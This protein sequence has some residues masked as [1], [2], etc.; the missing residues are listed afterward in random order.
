MLKIIQSNKTEVLFDHLL[1]EYRKPTDARSVFEP[2][3]VIVP[4]KVL[5]EWLKT[6]VADQTGISTLVTTE[7]WGRYFLGLMQRVLRTYERLASEKDVPRVPDVPMLSKNVM[8]WQIF[9]YLLQHA[10]QILRDDK[11]PLY[12]FIQP[13]LADKQAHQTVSQPANAS[14]TAQQNSTTDWANNQSL[15]GDTR[16]SDA[17][18]NRSHDQRLWQFAGDMAA[19]LSRYLTY[20]TDWLTQWNREQALPIAQMIAERDDFF[21]RLNGRSTTAAD[22]TPD[23]LVEHYKTLEAAQRFLWQTLFV[24]DFA[25]RQA[26]HANF[27]QALHERRDWI[28]RACRAQLPAS[29]L[30]FTVQQLPPSEL[31]EIERLAELT[32]ITLLHFNPS[33]QFWADIVDKNWLLQQQMTSEP[34]AELREYGHTLLSRFGKQSREVFAMLVSLSGN[35]YGTIT[36]QDA[37]DERA[38]H[39]TLLSQLQYDILMLDERQTAERLRD[40]VQGELNFDEKNSQATQQKIH[41]LQQLASIN[42]ANSQKNFYPNHSALDAIAQLQQAGFN[43]NEAFNTLL[44]KLKQEA[45]R[46]QPPWTPPTIDNS[47]AIHAC[48]STLRQLEVLRGMIVGWL[49]HTDVPTDRPKQH[50]SL[51]DILVLLPDIE[52]EQALIEAIFPDGVGTDGYTL[53]AKVTGVTSKD[54]NQFWQAIVGFYTL[55]NHA[56]ARFGRLEVFD[57]LRLPPL[58]ES[59]GLNLTQINRACELLTEAGFVRGFDERHLQTTLH[60]ADDDYRYS[61]AYALE[62]LVAGLLMPTAAVT[63]FGDYQNLSGHHEA[64]VPLAGVTLADTPII[65]MLCDL[66][67]MLNAKRDIG[68]QA[69]LIGAWLREIEDTIQGVFRQFVQ[70]KALLSIFAALNALRRNIEAHFKL[71]ADPTQSETQTELPLKLDFVLHSVAE[72]LASQQVSAEPAG[73]ITFARI[74]AV[75]GVPYKLV[76]MLNLNLNDFPKR[77]P[78]NRYDLMQAALGKRGDR[79]READDLGA[80]LDALLCAREACWLFYNAKSTTDTHEHLPA[81]PVQELLNFLQDEVEYDTPTSSAAK[82]NAEQHNATQQNSLSNITQSRTFGQ[83]VAQYLVTHHQALPFDAR[84]FEPLLTTD[85][86][87]VQQAQLNQIHQA[88]QHLAPP[89]RLWQQV[90]QALYQDKT[91]P[92]ALADIWGSA[93]LAA[94]LEAWQARK[95]QIAQQSHDSLSVHYRELSAIIRDVQDPAQA[96]LCAQCIDFIKKYEA[97]AALEPLSIDYLDSYRL[98][99]LLIQQLLADDWRDAMDDTS[100]AIYNALLPAG[101][102]RY[103]TLNEQRTQIQQALQSLSERLT[104]AA[105][106][107]ALTDEAT[108]EARLQNL[109]TILPILAQHLGI[110]ANQPASKQF[111]NWLTISQETNV[112]RVDV[113]TLDDNAMPSETLQGYVLKAWLPKDIQTAV[114][115]HYLPKNNKA[116]HQLNFWLHHLC[117]QIARQTSHEQVAQHHGSALWQY[118][119]ALLYLPPIEHQQAYTYL[120]DCLMVWQLMQ[121]QI[122]I[123]PPQVSCDYIQKATEQ[124]NDKPKLDVWLQTHVTY[125]EVEHAT[126]SLWQWLL[127]DDNPWVIVPFLQHLTGLLYQPMLDNLKQANL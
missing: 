41:T 27:W 53:P 67:Q 105:Q 57:W 88:K 25:T 110:P 96:F 117:W 99:D 35:E 28:Q 31:L 119:D 3:D 82:Q 62:R 80:F 2:F 72:Q 86:T 45:Q 56:G 42:Q 91:E 71:T 120:Q 94:W 4:S 43:R 26:I 51:S 93:Q 15:L 6:Q 69:Q 19:V 89:A 1:A 87:P 66:Y 78:L 97:Q 49:N 38:P 92:N 8:Q 22:A 20:R 39:D 60:T 108:H 90:Y 21:N 103:L 29:L 113:P 40:L 65:A 116:R 10:A 114:W 47:L 48:H 109:E 64:I 33:M 124:P 83:Q 115:L 100:S 122:T 17:A 18:E 123:L 75:R 76:A 127:D 95:P 107:S 118:H 77:E 36:W 112:G 13:L 44:A 70:G 58:Y 111:H 106:N 101:I 50:R 79:F 11:H 14:S 52:A 125:D 7:F 24:Q 63:Q 5:G 81:S 34:A 126:Y 121:A 59:F 104:Q 98:N 84:Y 68:R 74:G 16:A 30:L 102:N 9:G 32:D 12:A 85:D 61:F 46:N 54:I 37:F 73:V 23:W 55:L